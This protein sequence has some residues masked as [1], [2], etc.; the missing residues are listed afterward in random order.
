[1][2]EFRCG[3]SYIGVLERIQ[4]IPQEHHNV[5]PNFLTKHMAV[6]EIKELS[7]RTDPSPWPAVV[8][9]REIKDGHGKRRRAIGCHCA[10][11]RAEGR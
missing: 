3:R 2:P 5:R 10:A 4:S 7:L 8:C 6:G 11:E 1:M 9:K